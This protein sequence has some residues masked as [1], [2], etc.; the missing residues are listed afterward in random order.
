M[1]VEIW[2]DVVC[3]WCYI[4]KRRFEAALERFGHRDEVEV[5]W[6]AFE[7]DP[8]ATSASAAE[9]ARPD[10]YATRL[11]AKYGTSLEQA[12]G[13]L[14]SMTAAAAEEGL[15]F[16]FERA[17]RANTADAHQVVL[18]AGEHGLQ[19]AV[20]ERLMRACFTEGEAVGDREVLVRLAAEAGL[21]AEEVRAV[22][23]E[24]RLLEAVRAEE[25]EAAALGI[26]GVPF[27]VVDRRYGVS[28]AQPPEHLLAVLQRAWEDSRPL[29]LVGTG[30]DAAACGP[31]GCAL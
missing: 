12:R 16:H 8:T 24:G 26:R 11:A 22:L 17:V 6:K 31:D 29:T 9:T 14:A 21:D 19:D 10:D 13:M 15:D 27:F 1:K 28:G 18:L 20:E 2:S 30:D 3:P 23:A 7:L 25:A 4:G 5:E